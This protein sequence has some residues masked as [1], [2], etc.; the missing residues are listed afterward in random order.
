MIVVDAS[1]IGTFLIPDEAG[2]FADFARAVCAS[3]PLHAP[4]HCPVEIASLI[5]KAWRR[6]RLTDAQ[7]RTAAL[8]ADALAINFIIGKTPPVAELVDGSQA[9]GLTAYDTAY[10]LLAEHLGAPL[11]TDDGA[12]RRVAI[13]Q[14]MRVLMP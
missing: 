2:P 1:A 11:L 4:A 7:A 12:L 14:G 6:K 3:E 8:V 13:E 9:L 10:Y 5:R